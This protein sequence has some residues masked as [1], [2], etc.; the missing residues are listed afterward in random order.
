M[1]I[2]RSKLQDV[3]RSFIDN[4][5]VHNTNQHYKIIAPLPTLTNTYLKGYGDEII[6]IQDKGVFSF[7]YVSVSSNIKLQW[8]IKTMCQL[9]GKLI[10]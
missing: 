10:K 7:P 2:V 3:V 5:L 8:N 6:A 4:N 1:P 9:E